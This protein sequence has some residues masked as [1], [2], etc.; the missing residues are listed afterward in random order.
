MD[1]I[2]KLKELIPADAWE[3]MLRDKEETEKAQKAKDKEI[4]DKYSKIFKFDYNNKTVDLI[5][6]QKI[7]PETR[8]KLRNIA[9][10]FPKNKVLVAIQTLNA[11]YPELKGKEQELRIQFLED[12]PDITDNQLTDYLSGTPDEN[13]ETDLEIF[14]MR[15]FQAIL[16]MDS[17]SKELIETPIV[18]DNKINALW[19]TVD[20]GTIIEAVGFFRKK[21]GY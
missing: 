15:Y 18:V 13:F 2:E 3:K 20:Y 16:S 17:T 9:R 21:V 10:E 7:T 19:Q 1:N 14:H 6:K 4:E 8:H 12:N 5:L 11:K